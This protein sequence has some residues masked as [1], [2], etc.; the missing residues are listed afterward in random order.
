MR[1]SYLKS[2]KTIFPHLQASIPTLQSQNTRNFSVLSTTESDAYLSQRIQWQPLA[3]GRAGTQATLRVMAQLARLAASDP[4]FV[5]LASR[6]GTL[7]GVE[8]FVRDRF[9]YRD[10]NEEIIRD[11]RFMLADM[12]R[13][14][15]GRTVGLEG[16]CDDVATLYGALAAALHYPARLRA[17]RYNSDTPF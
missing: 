15:S 10:E 13:D 1:D 2:L 12:G 17:I 8:A 11:P 5:R 7:G 4:D 16:D 9:V 3:P 6:L 14:D